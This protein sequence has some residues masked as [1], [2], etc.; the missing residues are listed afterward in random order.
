MKTKIEIHAP[1]SVPFNSSSL[2]APEIFLPLMTEKEVCTIFRI[3]RR[4]LYTWRSKGL[5]PYVK[6]GKTVRIRAT[7]VKG[8]I[9]RLTI[10]RK[11][12]AQKGC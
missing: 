4:Q 12:G 2:V 1:E 3:C 9:D 11:P 5:M 7:D 10:R 8:L 6:I